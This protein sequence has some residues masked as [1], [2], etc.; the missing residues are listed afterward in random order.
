VLINYIINLTSNKT[1]NQQQEQQ[2][3]NKYVDFIPGFAKRREIFDKA[4][5]L[6]N[7]KKFPYIK[8]PIELSYE[9]YISE[10]V[11]P[12]NKKF[13]PKTDEDNRPITMPNNVNCK[14]VILRIVRHRLQDGSQYLT[15]FSQII[16]HD[17]HGNKKVFTCDSPEKFTKTIFNTIKEYS[18]KQKEIVSYCD[19]P[20][21]SEEIYEMPFTA[22][23]VDLLYSQRY[24]GNPY[25]MPNTRG[26]LR[27]VFYIKDHQNGG[28]VKEVFWSSEKE[29][30]RLFKEMDFDHLWNSLY[31]PQ[32]IRE[33]MLMEKMGVVDSDKSNNN[34]STRAGPSTST[35]NTSAYK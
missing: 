9:R 15:S 11:N 27:F 25:F 16:G 12:K 32:A 6:R 7:G 22:E 14:K 1:N 5:P 21:G 23:N 10:I 28:L 26:N 4:P 18:P 20:T 2:D 30:L 17:V 24:D 13:Y 19:G 34:G 8:Q 31:L 33:Q 3:I 35:N 29:S